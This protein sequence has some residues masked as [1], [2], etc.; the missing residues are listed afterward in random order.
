[1]ATNLGV[2]NEHTGDRPSAA[3][4]PWCR[5]TGRQTHPD[6]SSARRHPSKLSPRTANIFL[7]AL[8]AILL[9][10]ACGSEE[11]GAG[12]T[13]DPDEPRPGAEATREQEPRTGTA[14]ATP[15]PA[16]ERAT[17][18]ASRPSATASSSTLSPGSTSAVTAPAPGPTPGTA[19]AVRP[20][21]IPPSQ[22]SQETDLAVLRGL[23]DYIPNL[24]V[25]TNWFDDDISIH[26]FTGVEVQGFREGRVIG[27][28]PA[29]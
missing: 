9:L 12:P 7:L 3:R 14:T 6:V 13:A 2:P 16:R 26:R 25:R 15:A 27:P 17:P 18:Q 21:L 20:T 4:L 11:T 10:I 23:L 29:P 22:T 8:L 28:H 1:M 19:P 24:D 5:A